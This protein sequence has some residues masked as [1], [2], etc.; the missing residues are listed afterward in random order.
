MAQPI[1]GAISMKPR[2]IIAVFQGDAAVEAMGA[3]V[4][5]RFKALKSHEIRNLCGFCSIMRQNGCSMAHFDGFY[6]SYSILQI[7]K[8]FD[9]LRLGN[10]YVLNI[11]IKSELKI[12]QKEQKILK[13]MRQNQYYLQFLNKPIHIF[14]YVENDGFYQYQNDNTVRRVSPETVARYMC[15]Q[16]IDY[17]LDP[18]RL[19][20]PSNYLISPFNSTD[21]FMRDSYFLTSAQEKVK[22]ETMKELD[23]TPFMFF[24]LT[25]NAGTGKT[26]TMYDIAKSFIETKRDVRIIHCGKL[27]QGHET[28]RNKYGWN[29]VSIR[30]IA[31]DKNNVFIGSNSIIFIDEAQRIRVSQLFALVEKAVELQIPIFFSF[32]TKQY[33]RS[34]ETLNVSEYLSRNYPGV[35]LSEKKL[36]NKIRT[37]K[38]MA[39][40]ITNMFEKGKSHDN[41]NYNCITVDYF[42]NI[43][44]VKEYMAF[45]RESGWTAITYTTSTYDADP[46][47]E[48]TEFGSYNAHDVIGQEFSK[49]VFVM[50][51]NFTYSPNGKLQAQHSYYSA[52]GMLYQIVT[53]VVDELKIIVLGNRSLYIDLL[54]IKAMS[55]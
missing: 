36:T 16:T 30:D 32:D 34:G 14:T 8:E 42:D 5:K 1:G 9:L 40:F 38:A 25:A 52:S 26:L 53:R 27:N 47:D 35:R 13:Q 24:C 23:E 31:R 39:S 50:D 7:G 28:L 3:D 41:L 18:D 51:N 44:S 33:L 19:F 49:V 4:D 48:L 29:I 46:Y 21:A 22:E 54:E 2:N 11:E 10:D 15:D 17:S 20:L 6:V 55:I 45:L 37:N 43:E 12:A